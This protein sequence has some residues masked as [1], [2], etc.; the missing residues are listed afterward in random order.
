MQIIDSQITTKQ[1]ATKRVVFISMLFVTFLVV[2]NLTAFKIAEIHFTENF[3]FN[4]PASMI[5]FP[6]TYFFDDILTEVYG[7]KMSRLI[8]WGGLL[9]SCM[10]T[11][12]T[13]LAVHLPAAPIWDAHTGQGAKAYALIFQGSLRIFFASILAF[14]FG[15]FFNSIVLAK[16]KVAT[17]G[18]YFALRVLASTAIGVGLD[19]IIFCNI[20]FWDVLPHHLIWK[21]I[22]T[23]YLFK[24][25]YEFVM[26]PVTYSLVNYLKRM[27]NVDYY[28]VETKFNPFSVSLMD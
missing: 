9:C 11:M 23:L 12:C 27:D 19:S 28:D 2:S 3:F 18:K 15:E 16:L 25:F 21:M 13:W 14:F 24:L 6:L 4:F 1:V 22:L 10:V 7:F 17:K 8:I 20:A 26:L 5:F